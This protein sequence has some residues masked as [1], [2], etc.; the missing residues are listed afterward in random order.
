LVQQDLLRIVVAILPQASLSRL[1]MLWPTGLLAKGWQP[2][3]T[4]VRM[5]AWDRWTR[6]RHGR[7]QM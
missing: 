6:D 3:T 1:A 7:Y 5:P 4:A 2:Q